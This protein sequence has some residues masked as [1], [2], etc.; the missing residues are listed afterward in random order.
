MRGASIVVV[1]RNRKKELRELLA[2]ARNQTIPVEL[3]VLDDGSTDGTGE[4]VC[5]EFPMC[6][7]EQFACNRGPTFHRNRGIELASN[8][9]VFPVDDDTQFVSS[10]TV[11]QTLK[12]FDDPRIGAVAIPFINVRQDAIVQQR[13]PNNDGTYVTSEFI[14]AAHALRRDLFL[15]LGGYREDF[16]YQGEEPDL[17]IRM[18]E[19]GYFVKLGRAD[20]MYHYQSPIRERG[21]MIS[22]AP[23]NAVMFVWLN[24]PTRYLV[25]HLIVSSYRHLKLGIKVRAPRL[26]ALGL[27]R[28]YV[29]IFRQFSSRKPVSLRTYRTFRQLRA[30]GSLQLDAL[31]AQE[32]GKR[33][34]P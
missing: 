27:I 3:I 18:L 10:R 32:L 7:F 22:Y 5:S 28:G 16:F 30:T 13:A 11:E 25:P 4:M 20:P 1:T 15:E 21:R 34:L 23:R 31:S 2:S 19:A 24:V 12:E 6:R 8:D 9:I 17:C 29:D 33:T 26:K 14:G